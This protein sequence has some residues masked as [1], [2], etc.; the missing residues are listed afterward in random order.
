[1]NKIKLNLGCGTKILDGWE[2]YD[3]FPVNDKV[4]FINLE[5][6]PLSFEDNYVNEILLDN[7]IEHL[8][9]NLFDFIMEIWRILKPDGIVTIVV[10][11]FRNVI[12]HVRYQFNYQWIN[13]LLINPI[14]TKKRWNLNKFELIEWQDNN[15]MKQLLHIILPPITFQFFSSAGRIS[16]K[17]KAIKKKI[18]R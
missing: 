18:K 10:P 12:G 17:L 14:R 13:Q 5:D 11:G 7:V 9:V 1:M 6:L 16:W 15:K 4:K 8:F 3:K 2:N